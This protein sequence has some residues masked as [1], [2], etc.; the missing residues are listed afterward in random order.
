MTFLLGEQAMFG[1][2]P[3]DVFAFDG[4]DALPALSKGP[5]SDCSFRA[6]AKN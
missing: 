2:D 6:A 1:H 5:G 3:A 4:C